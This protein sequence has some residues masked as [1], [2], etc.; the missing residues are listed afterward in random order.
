MR[1]NSKRAM[2]FLFVDLWLLGAGAGT[3][4]ALP[5]QSEEPPEQGVADAPT[6]R[7]SPSDLVI[8][9]ELSAT[10]EVQAEGMT[11]LAGFDLEL[12]FNSQLVEAMSVSEGSFLRGGNGLT[13]SAR[14]KIDNLNGIVSL[15]VGRMTP[16]GVSGKGTLAK[17][18][19][20]AKQPGAGTLTLIN[21]KLVNTAA[22]EIQAQRLHAT[23]TAPETPT[24]DVNGDGFVNIFDIV[25]VGQHFGQ[26]SPEDVSVDVNRDGVVNIFDL[27]LVG[28][29]YGEFIPSAAP[30][31]RAAVVVQPPDGNRNAVKRAL[32]ALQAAPGLPG[33]DIAIETLRT[34]LLE[35]RP[36]VVAET[37]LL[38]N[39]PNPFNPETWIPYQLAV[40]AEVVVSIYD[41]RGT[42]ARRFALGQQ[43]PG[44]YVARARALRW[45]GRSETG[46]RVSSGLYF[47]ELRAGDYAAVK[48]MV[49]VK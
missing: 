46:E 31:A 35:T 13:F 33:R 23:I 27:V 47:Y 12:F 30:A 3:V 16:G 15:A 26:S 40:E 41:S 38:D 7:I 8:Y 36:T 32:A 18:R 10:V 2:A 21:L 9:R 25:L 43:P 45:D 34:W 42:L 29:H 4:S 14:S 20:Q 39:Y 5:H 37:R 49:V 44:Y 24:W 28:K 19:L 17:I 22:K 48:P 1:F 11:D 6:V